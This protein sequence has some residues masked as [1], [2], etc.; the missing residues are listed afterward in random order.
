MALCLGAPDDSKSASS[1]RDTEIELDVALLDSEMTSSATEDTKVSAAADTPSLSSPA[2]PAR[3]ARNVL[4]ATVGADTHALA[5]ARDEAPHA[6]EAS[7]DLDAA[8][9]AD[10]TAFGN[11]GRGDSR[12]HHSS[13]HATILA[14]RAP[15]FSV[16]RGPRLL[17][18]SP[19]C[20]D[21]FGRAS[22]GAGTLALVD[23]DSHGAARLSRLLGDDDVE[24]ALLDASRACVERLSFEPA[25]DESGEA[26]EGTARLRLRPSSE[27]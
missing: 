14:R 25:R 24:P 20:S 16:T 5:D 8:L 10:A 9:L 17:A 23:V 22:L 18:S 11:G 13:A 4:T 19:S 7:D 1:E 15:R 26:H 6:A 27:G 2:K 21:L 12:I 3:S